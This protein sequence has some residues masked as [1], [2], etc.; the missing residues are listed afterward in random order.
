M[1]FPLPSEPSP[2]GD[3]MLCIWTFKGKMKVLVKKMTGIIFV[4]LFFMHAVFYTTCARYMV[5]DLLRS[6]GVAP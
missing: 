5:M 3:R 1:S 4:Q 2:H 6:G